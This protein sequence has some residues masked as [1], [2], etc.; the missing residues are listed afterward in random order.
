MFILSAENYAQ[1]RLFVAC[2][3]KHFCVHVLCVI[4]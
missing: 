3:Y 2:A 1:S 4:D